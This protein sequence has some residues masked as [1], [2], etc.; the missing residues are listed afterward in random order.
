MI[1]T[2]SFS[3]TSHLCCAARKQLSHTDPYR[4]NQPSKLEAWLYYFLMPFTFD[5]LTL[6]ST[7]PYHSLRVKPCI[8]SRV[9][10]SISNFPLEEQFYSFLFS[11]RCD[12]KMPLESKKCFNALYYSNMQCEIYFI[13]GYY[14][15]YIY[16]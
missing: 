10:I 13:M 16:A 11:Y 12:A 9:W 15:I 6:P 4:L 14:S 1:S 2:I 7:M 8:N 5:S 3:P